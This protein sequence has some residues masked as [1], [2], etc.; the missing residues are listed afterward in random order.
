ML[1]IAKKFKKKIS[2]LDLKI[3]AP[4]ETSKTFKG[5][6]ILKAKYFFKRTRL[7]CISDDSGLEVVALKNKPGIY[8]ARWAKKLGS[9][10]FAMKRILNLLK[11]KKNRN[12]YFV[13]SLTL[14]N[15][16]GK[17]F[18]STYRLQGKISH[19]ILGK[20]GFGYDSIF[21]PKGHKKTFGQTTKK[22][23]M[24]M[25]HRFYAFKKLRKHPNIFKFT[26]ICYIHI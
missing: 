13:C 20:N 2:P 14:I 15:E 3:K 26:T 19:K 7:A 11:T 16:K 4:K 18:N 1:F 5:N 9:F 8:S 25:D 10:N 12:A 23:K 24:R 6:S 21:I 22:K 17:I